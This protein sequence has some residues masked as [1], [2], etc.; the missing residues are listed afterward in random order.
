MTGTKKFAMG[1][2]VGSVLGAAGA[3]LFAPMKGAKLRRDLERGA[4]KVAHRVSETA[5]EVRDRGKDLYE[6]TR[7]TA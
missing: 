1:F 7:R 4:R 5:E 3:I 2:F 6:A